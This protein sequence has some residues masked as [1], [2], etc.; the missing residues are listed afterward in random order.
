MKIDILLQFPNADTQAGTWAVSEQWIDFDRAPEEGARCTIA[1][2]AVELKSHLEQT[3]PDA[4]VRITA[5][6]QPGR[7]VIALVAEKLTGKGEQY[8]LIPGENRLEIRGDGRVGVL[9]GVYEL[10]KMQ[11]WRWYEPGPMGEYGPEPTDRL[12]LPETA[13]R[14]TTTATLGRGFSIEGQLKESA[15]L[16][17]WMARNR[18]NIYAHRPN[19]RALMR[20]LGIDM[21]DGGHIFEE[22]LNPDRLTPSGQ[23]LWQAHPAWYG[24]PAQGGKCRERALQTQ[25]CVSQPDLMEFLCEDLLSHIMNQWHGADLIDVWGFDTWGSVCC[26]EKCRALGNGTDQTLHM[27]SQFRTYLNRA[28]REGRLD[29]DV[30]MVLCAYE[31]TSTL[32][33]PERDVPQNLIDAGDYALYATIVRCY[34]H[35]FDDPDCSYN[36]EYAQ[37]LAGWNQIKNKLPMMVLEYYNVSKFEDLPLLFTEHMAHDLRYYSQNGVSGF[38]YMHVPLVNWGVRALTQTL[39]A[40]F[41]WNPDAD[42]GQILRDYFRCRYGEY[43]SRMQTVYDRINK[44]SLYITSWRAWK[45]RS[46][47]SCFQAWDGRRPEAPLHVDDHFGTPENFERM[48]AETEALL[49]EAQSLLEKVLWEEKHNAA[50]IDAGIASAANPIELRKSRMRSRLRYF[51]EEDR[52]LV[53]YGVD[54]LQL[55]VRMGQ[56]YNAMYAA[57]DARAAALWQQIEELENRMERYYMPMTFDSDYLGIISYDALTRTQMK[58]TIARCR[59]YRIENKLEDTLC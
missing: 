42:P 53:A 32:L 1:Y 28:R 54:T 52:R 3:L 19:T 14:C 13:L 58:D 47:L 2:A 49:L 55:M 25:F 27:A 56:Y 51:L 39:Y 38:A 40:E 22:I 37:V 20:K 24:T 17:V 30:R 44:A 15:D 43:A 7:F 36:R 9:Y 57:E 29:R 41:S 16:M 4:A 6:E 34:A 46:L 12:I 35:T 48:G 23:T 31:G 10:L 33:P 5:Q 21:R 26:C 18:L 45:D 50:H 59:K 11:G 8:S